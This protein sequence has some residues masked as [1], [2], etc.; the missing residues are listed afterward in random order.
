ML[1]S[2]GCRFLGRICAYQHKV[3]IQWRLFPCQAQVM[4]VDNIKIIIIRTTCCFSCYIHCDNPDGTRIG[5]G[6]SIGKNISIRTDC[7]HTK[8][9]SPDILRKRKTVAGA[10]TAEAMGARLISLLSAAY[11]LP[12]HFDFA[13]NSR[14][15]S[16]DR[17]NVKNT[18]VLIKIAGWR[19]PGIKHAE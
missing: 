3:T 9:F 19:C 16:S 11:K 15:L 14:V 17:N 12:Y 10:R 2:A 5:L 8:S 7:I 6:V 18:Q 4:S 13:V 1:S